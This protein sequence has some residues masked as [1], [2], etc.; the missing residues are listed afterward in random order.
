MRRSSP[1]HVDRLKDR[2]WIRVRKYW[3]HIYIQILISQI[4][5]WFRTILSIPQGEELWQVDIDPTLIVQARAARQGD[6][7]LPGRRMQEGLGRRMTSWKAIPTARDDGSIGL[8]SPHRQG[9]IP[10]PRHDEAAFAKNVR[11]GLAL[12]HLKVGA[13]SA[14]RK[15]GCHGGRVCP[16]TGAVFVRPLLTF[17]LILWDHSPQK[18]KYKQA[19]QGTRKKTHGMLAF[20]SLGPFLRHGDQG[21]QALFL[22]IRRW[23]RP[24]GVFILEPQPW[25]AY[26]KAQDG[27][28]SLQAASDAAMKRWKMR[29]LMTD[30]IWWLKP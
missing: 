2:K 27:V 25:K 13:P 8:D 6:A 15:S 9:Q 16:A 11:R 26:K 3:M 22:R 24:T 21:L 1:W 19:A 10:V 20:P 29:I 23:L 5:V 7:A 18:A 4:G 28:R 17:E 30:D 14:P 12:K